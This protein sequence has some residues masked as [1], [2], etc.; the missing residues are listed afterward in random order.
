MPLPINKKGGCAY[1]IKYMDRESAYL[2]K[3]MEEINILYAM[4]F[5]IT[6]DNA[7]PRPNITAVSSYLHLTL[8]IE[9]LDRT[10]E[11]SKQASNQKPMPKHFLT[12]HWENL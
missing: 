4:E 6:A 12:R 3:Y 8:T 9:P 2:I 5:S 10:W 11:L 7:L 1:I